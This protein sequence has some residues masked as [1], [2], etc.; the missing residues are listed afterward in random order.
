MMQLRMGMNP[1]QSPVLLSVVILTVS[2]RVVI[3]Q[4][5]VPAPAPTAM[6]FPSLPPTASQSGIAYFRELLSAKPEERRSFSQARVLRI[7]RFSRG[8][9]VTSKRCR[10]MRVTPDCAPWSFVTIS[11]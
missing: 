11:R 6:R 10:R 5:Q 2:M 3:G 4:A 9:F 8:E 7:A 1:M